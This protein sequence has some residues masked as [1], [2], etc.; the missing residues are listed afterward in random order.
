MEKDDMTTTNANI[1]WYLDG[2]SCLGDACDDTCCKGWGMQLSA[3]TVATYEKHAPELLEFIT[4]GEADHIMKRDDTTDYCV[5]Y[6]KGWCG[7]HK[8]YGTDM[9]GDA[10]HFFPR[11]TKKIGN[12]AV[13]SAALSCP[14]IS[15]ALL[16]KNRPDTDYISARI[17]RLPHSVKDYQ[18]SDL[19]EDK[20][21]QVHQAFLNLVNDNAITSIDALIAIKI[22]VAQLHNV[23]TETWGVAAPFYLRNALSSLPQ[24]Q[25]D[26]TDNL[27]VLNMLHVLVTLAKSSK[28]ERLMHTISNMDTALDVSFDPARLT[29]IVGEDTAHKL[30]ALQMTYYGAHHERIVHIMQ[31]WLHGQLSL[32]MFPYA[33]LGDTMEQ[34]ITII[35]VRYATVRLALLSHIMIYNALE[36]DD[37]VRI[38]QSLS[39]F[40]DHLA[41]AQ[42][43]ISL[44]EQAGWTDN[45]RLAGLLS[46]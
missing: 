24:A 13:M 44:Y 10:C 45:A 30:T 33:G 9:L 40:M 18:P 16:F 2:F 32:S 34:R 36:E 11:S 23:S 27:N 22:A 43:S 38:V 12:E 8:K 3:Q 39:R 21:M 15:R 42:T 5:K 37:A 26:A 1:A 14:E 25:P 20:S 19:S 31:R 46:V 35:A 6:D 28:R 17:D 7:I 41:D 29:V 4:S